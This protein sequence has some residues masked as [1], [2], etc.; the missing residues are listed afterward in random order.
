MHRNASRFGLGYLSG[1]AFAADPVH[2]QMIG[3]FRGAPPTTGTSAPASA[4]ANRSAAATPQRQQVQQT[5]GTTLQGAGTSPNAISGIMANIQDEPNKPWDPSDREFD[6]PHASG[7]ARYAHGLY[8]EGGDNWNRYVQWL[9]GRDW[10]D[11]QLQTQFLVENL[12]AHYPGTWQ[13]LNAAQTPGQAAQIFNDEYLKP[14]I[15][16]RT[17]RDIKY[18][19]GVPMYQDGAMPQQTTPQQVSQQSPT[20]R[21]IVRSRPP[22]RDA[23]R[24]RDG[25]WYVHRNGRYY[26]VHTAENEPGDAYA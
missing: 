23:R 20:L 17:Q 25:H 8:Q 26:R 19:R 21:Q 10:R 15:K 12:K 11:P 7:E 5:V 22:M 3:N 16:Y 24:G 13:R 1:R 4:P 9:N 18:G 2:T 6:Q 14:A